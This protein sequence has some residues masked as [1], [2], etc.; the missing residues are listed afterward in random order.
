MADDGAEGSGLLGWW[1]AFA[2]K[3]S[4]YRMRRARYDSKIEQ[5]NFSQVYS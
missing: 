4:G 1:E 3:S 5:V 2:M